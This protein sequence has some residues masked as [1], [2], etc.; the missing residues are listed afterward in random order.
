MLKWH[1]NITDEFQKKIGISNYAMLWL[2]Y[3]KGLIL[4]L[5]IY[6]FLIK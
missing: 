3:L 6:H 4:G 2:S 5:L 1:K